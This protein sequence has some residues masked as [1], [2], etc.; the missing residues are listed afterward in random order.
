MHNCKKNPRKL[1]IQKQSDNKIIKTQ[2]I[3]LL[4]L[5]KENETVQH[6]IITDIKNLFRYLY[7][8]SFSK[9]HDSQDNRGRGKLF[10]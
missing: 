7:G 8:F 6:R 5:K 9:I 2:G 1:K 10:L 4:K 3:Y